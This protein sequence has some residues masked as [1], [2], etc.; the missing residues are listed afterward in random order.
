MTYQEYQDLSIY[1]TSP[2]SEES[3]MAKKL[4]RQK[5]ALK[6]APPERALTAEGDNSEED[7][8]AQDFEEESEEEDVVFKGNHLTSVGHSL[9]R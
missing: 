2:W 1:K 7:T 5:K 6:N 8:E 9:L 3:F 4:I